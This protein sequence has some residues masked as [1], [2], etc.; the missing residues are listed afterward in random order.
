MPTH[1]K[2][3][4]ESIDHSAGALAPSLGLEGWP[5][6]PDSGRLTTG[7]LYLGLLCAVAVGVLN[8]PR[9]S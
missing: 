8:S 7:M 3:T 9:L 5:K 6:H 1:A 4:A 2:A